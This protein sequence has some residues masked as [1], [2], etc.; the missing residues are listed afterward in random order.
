MYYIEENGQRWTIG[1]TFTDTITGERYTIEDMN[2]NGTIMGINEAG[3]VFWTHIH[4]SR[5][6]WEEA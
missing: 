1:D 2:N 4:D 3:G 5:V 6:K